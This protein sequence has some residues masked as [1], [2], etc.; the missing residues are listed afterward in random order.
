MSY[1]WLVLL[2]A[3]SPLEGLQRIALRNQYARQAEAAFQRKNYLQAAALYEKVAKAEGDAPLLPVRLNLAHS[4]FQLHNFSK[5]SPLYRALLKSAS[6]PGLKS[7][8]ANQLAVIEAEEG[9]YTKALA[10]SKQAL[11]ADELNQEARFNYE[12]LQKYLLLHPEKGEQL[13]P[14][15]NQNGKGR[16]SGSP[17]TGTSQGQTQAG[18]SGQEPAGGKT[19]SANNGQTGQD[20]QRAQGDSPGTQR[21]Q[22]QNQGNGAGAGGSGGNRPGGQNDALLQTRYERLQKINLSPEKARQLLDAMRQEETQYL[23]QLP[24]RRAPKKDDGSPDW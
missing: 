19:A 16:Q 13:P 15:R 14:P 17:S 23:Q 10:F 18:G 8:V 9:N 21:G 7:M 24:R 11:I 3:F 4:Y 20:Q 2:L 6:D 22:T 12:L 1:W 5:A